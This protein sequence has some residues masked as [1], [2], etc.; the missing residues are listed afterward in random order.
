M[1]QM[2]LLKLKTSTS[3]EFQLGYLSQYRD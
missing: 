3:I 2:G 1:I